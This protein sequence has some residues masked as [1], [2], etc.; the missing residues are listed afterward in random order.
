[1]DPLAMSYN[2]VG[3]SGPSKVGLVQAIGLGVW[4]PPL[5]LLTMEELL[6]G[7]ASFRTILP[8]AFSFLINLR[9]IQ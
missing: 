6:R 4:G 2:G 5:T 9:I 8:V 1:M 3:L 7:W